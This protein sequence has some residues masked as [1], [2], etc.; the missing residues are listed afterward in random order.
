M[1]LDD[2]AV[3]VVGG[4]VKLHSRLIPLAKS[5][6]QLFPKIHLYIDNI[7]NDEIKSILKVSNHLGIQF[8][9]MPL[10]PDLIGSSFEGGWFQS[11]KRYLQVFKD[12]YS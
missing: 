5:W 8:H 3:A 1:S 6:F 4:R 11:Q 9:R 7:T 2:I 12:L 10:F